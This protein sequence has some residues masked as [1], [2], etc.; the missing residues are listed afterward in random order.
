M[1]IIILCVL[2][3]ITLLIWTIKFAPRP[4]LSGKE[5][6]PVID[7]SPGKTSVLLLGDSNIRGE[8]AANLI[9]RITEKKSL[10]DYEFYNGGYNFACVEDLYQKVQWIK[11]KDFKY[12]FILVGTFDIVNSRHGHMGMWGRIVAR[13]H[14]SDGPDD[15]G[16]RYNNLVRA[17]QGV[18][19]AQI[20]LLTLPT[21]AETVDGWGQEQSLIYSEVI[22]RVGGT[23]N[24]IVIDFNKALQ[25]LIFGQGQVGRIA[26]DY[27]GG[28]LMRESLFRYY[29]LWE[30]V[31]ETRRRS[32]M[33]WT[34]DLVHINTKGAELLAKLIGQFL[35]TKLKP[36]S[37]RKPPVEQ[38]AAPTEEEEFEKT[39]DIEDALPLANS[40]A[41][42]SEPG[43]GE[44]YPE[45]DPEIRGNEYVKTS[46]I[47][48][49]QETEEI[50]KQESE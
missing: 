27:D 45:I 13:N 36:M 29:F 4:P 44:I 40:D 22:R 31:G 37:K 42:D 33:R 14:P 8:L 11:T 47:D 9:G 3:L 18:S 43:T 30:Q 20:V 39:E 48:P 19:D 26:R 1:M 17:I 24:C 35:V 2:L 25:D 15:F 41:Y 32:G 7:T 12:I 50:K 34:T 49:N 28:S 21:I 5:F 46:E 23:N 10:S 16:D 38:A 6:T